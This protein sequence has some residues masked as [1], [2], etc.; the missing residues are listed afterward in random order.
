[1][2]VMAK[3][4]NQKIERIGKGLAVSVLKHSRDSY[5]L[6]PIREKGHKWVIDY[7]VLPDV[8]SAGSEM[9]VYGVIE[10]VIKPAYRD[11]GLI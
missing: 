10:H 4:D 5:E 3:K 1:M 8:L 6:A 7:R 2:I 11:A 9:E